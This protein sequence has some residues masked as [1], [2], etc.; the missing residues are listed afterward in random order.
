MQRF[1]T[2]GHS[3]GFNSFQRAVNGLSRGAVVR[4]S[5]RADPALLASA[6]QSCEEASSARMLA[7]RHA[8]R[9]DWE[10]PSLNDDDQINA[11]QAWLL[12][13]CMVLRGYHDA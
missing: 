8:A 13:N 6:G 5:N 3:R 4:L 1:G 12:G 11:K 2:A 10:L 9:C 7:A